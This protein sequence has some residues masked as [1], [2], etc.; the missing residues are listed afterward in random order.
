MLAQVAARDKE[1][2]KV[3]LVIINVRILLSIPLRTLVDNSSHF[4]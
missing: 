2:S 1:T 4:F 3:V